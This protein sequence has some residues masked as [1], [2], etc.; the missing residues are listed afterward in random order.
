MLNQQYCTG[1]GQYQAEEMKT[2]YGRE[3]SKMLESQPRD[4]PRDEFDQFLG[5]RPVV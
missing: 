1:I 4:E 5:W 2:G 3:S